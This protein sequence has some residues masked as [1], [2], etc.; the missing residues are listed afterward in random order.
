MTDVRTRF[1]PSPTGFIHVGGIRTAQ[2]AWLVARHSS[3]QFIL[4]LEDTDKKREVA[5]AKDHILKSLKTL[6][7]NY[8]EGP[9]VGG[10][11]G[12]YIQSERLD[13]YRKW[14]DK[15][16]EL[17]RAYTDPYSE[18]ELNSLRLEAQKNKKPFLFRN[19]RPNK[20]N[21]IQDNKPIRFLSQTKSYTWEDAVMGHMSF[22]ESSIDDF[23]LI[24][25]D[26]YPT[27]NFAHII[28]DIEMK[29][30]H[31]IRGQ[32]YLPSI[33]N[34]LNLYEAL[35]QSPPIFATLPHVLSE[36]GQ[37]KLSK[38]DGA[39]DILDYINQ[40]YLPE[41]LLSFIATLG[42]NDG[43]TQEVFTTKELIQKFNLS[44]VQRSGAQFDENRLK[45][46]NGVFIR[47]IEIEKLYELCENY[48][49]KEAEDYPREYKLKVLKIIQ[50]RMK[51]L[52]ELPE[53]SQFMF[54]DL[55][56]N[57]ELLNL[58]KLKDVSSQDK[59]SLL[60]KSKDILSQ[61]NFNLDDLNSKLNNLLSDT[62]Q[63]PA[64]LFSLIRV[65]TTQVVSS[66]ALGE[67]LEVLGKEKTLKRIDRQIESL[68]KN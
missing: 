11:L 28:D 50:E 10:D 23:I 4:R 20:L 58:G 22:S 47:K 1:A 51:Y 21:E 36:T 25:S 40:G 9:D 46:I 54:I 26:G 60:Q 53:L 55:P 56:V 32:E 59:I 45:W 2:F 15:L 29:I 38:R 19:H 65:A 14:A 30:T 67:T 66:P 43:T 57:L 41:A 68:N 6:G 24:K 61:S 34:Y 42:W 48:W 8:D 3:G 35:A 64:V 63:T 7:L 18:E 27:Y 62:N 49:P 16:I 44:R 31:V 37:K 33:P 13:I 12:P 39:K 52:S 5:G 17:G